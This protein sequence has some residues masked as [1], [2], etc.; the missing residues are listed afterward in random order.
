METKDL[1][2]C[3]MLAVNLDCPISLKALFDEADLKDTGVELDSHITLIYAQG[4]ELDRK[5]LMS[6]IEKIL[7]VEDYDSLMAKI[8]NPKVIPVLDV[9]DLG[10][11]EN[12]SDYVILKLKKDSVLFPYLYKINSGLREKYSI[13]SDFSDYTPHVSLAELQPG[14]AKEYLESE[15]LMAVLKDSVISLE[16]IFVSYG[17]SNEPEDRKQY[18][19]TGF[20]SVDRYFR[21]LHLKAE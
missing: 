18:F 2:S 17:A 13:S 12:D 20:H 3:L 9:F 11:F 8:S 16:D 6:D 15:V 14:K 5:V 4:K 10:S 1:N 7:G 21:L 19:L